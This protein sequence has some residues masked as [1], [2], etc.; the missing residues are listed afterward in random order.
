MKFGITFILLCVATLVN[1]QTLKP[2]STIVNRVD[3]K[4]FEKDESH[5]TDKNGIKLTNKQYHPVG[6]SRYGI[7]CLNE[8]ARSGDSTYYLRALDQLEY[9]KSDTLVHELFDG[10]GIGLPYLDEHFNLQPPWYSGMAQGLAVSFLLR[11]Y[12]ITQEPQL[13]NITKDIMYVMLQPDFKGGCL[14]K[15]DEDYLWIEEYPSCPASPQVLNGFIFALIGLVEYCEFF[16]GDNKANRLKNE[17]QQ[18]LKELLPTYDT[19]NWTR[20]NK[21]TIYPIRE[22]YLRVQIFQMQ[23]LYTITQDPYFLRQLCI[24]AGLDLQQ[25]KSDTIDFVHFDELQFLVPAL[26]EDD[27]LIMQ[28]FDDSRNPDEFEQA[29]INAGEVPSF[30]WYAF[31]TTV[32]YNFKSP[33]KF[34]IALDSSITQ[35]HIFYKHHWDQTLFGLEKW[36]AQKAVSSNYQVFHLQPG[37]YQFAIFYKT[38]KGSEKQHEVYQFHFRDP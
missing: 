31:A 23:Q 33:K 6:I 18:S 37:M 32:E 34:E 25:P 12:A 22:Y 14:S 10:K 9:Y 16:P 26:L 11:V 17:L 19:R 15:T 21:R 30:P 36:Q 3:V 1:G 8:F 27:K 20:Y 4:E 5:S 28:E 2:Y 29:R 13:I 35:A 38:E 7:L 24:W